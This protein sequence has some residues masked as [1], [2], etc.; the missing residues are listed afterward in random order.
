MK[1]KKQSETFFIKSINK[2]F[3][4]QYISPRWDPL[5][6]GKFNKNYLSFLI[7]C[8][9]ERKNINANNYRRIICISSARGGSHLFSSLFHNIN[10]CF[11]FDEAFSNLDLK[12]ITSRAF[13]IRGMYGINSLQDKQIKDL[14]DIFY[15]INDQKVLNKKNLPEYFDVDKDVIIYIFRNPLKTII[16]RKNAKKEK[17]E[18]NESVELFLNEFL[19][20]IKKYKYLKSKKYLVKA[21]MLEEFLFNIESELKSLCEFLWSDGAIKFKQR[22]PYKRFFKKFILCNSVPILEN[23]YLTSPLTKE[24]IVGSGG[25]FNPII[26]I[27]INRL[28]K[29]EFSLDNETKLICKKILGE[30][31]NNCFLNNKIDQTNLEYILTLV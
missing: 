12:A 10:G 16:S 26:D 18:T 28:S 11:C 23:E 9:K 25:M 13:M 27:S 5:L 17:W 1:N 6:N 24:K 20:N 3:P 21:F 15:M 4:F 19:A 7:K 14:R 31:L 2:I 29:A 22:I 30:E 8:L